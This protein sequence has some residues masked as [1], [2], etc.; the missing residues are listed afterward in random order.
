MFSPW[1]S[2]P[3]HTWPLHLALT[4]PGLVSPNRDLTT[5]PRA[6]P[7]FWTSISDRISNTFS[8]SN[9]SFRL[10]APFP[11]E[12]TVAICSHI[13]HVLSSSGNIEGIQQAFV[14]WIKEQSQ[15]NK[16]AIISRLLWN[17]GFAF[18]SDL[19]YTWISQLPI[20]VDSTFGLFVRYISSDLLPMSLS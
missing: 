10:A 6:H 3:L 2:L 7:V 5:F 1:A 8:V 14:D 18:S 9:S 4:Q 15:S 16:R 20:S 12:P 17:I 19:S 11:Q 13:S